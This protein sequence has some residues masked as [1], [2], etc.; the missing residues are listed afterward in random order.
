MD[1]LLQLARDSGYDDL[2]ALDF[3]LQDDPN[4]ISSR[5]RSLEMASGSPGLLH[6]VISPRAAFPSRARG[7]TWDLGLS[8]SFR[9][10]GSLD[11]LSG[12][13]GMGLSFRRG[14]SLSRD[15]LSGAE[16]TG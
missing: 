13:E 11:L 8:M 7:T 15:L 16:G 6:K 4:E 10:G 3:V 14:G 9:R 2:S 12:A 1:Q 5:A